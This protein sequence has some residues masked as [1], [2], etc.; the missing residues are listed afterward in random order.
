LWGNKA[1]GAKHLRRALT[2]VRKTF[3]AL[4]NAIL[5]IRDLTPEDDTDLVELRRALT[6]VE[7][8]ALYDDVIRAKGHCHEIG[9]I[10]DAHL[11]GW[12]SG[13]LDPGEADGMRVLFN[14]LRDSDGW[15]IDGMEN[16]LFEAKPLTADI[17]KALDEGDRAA[18]R[19]RA[20]EFNRTL[21]PALQKLSETVTYMLKLEMKFITERA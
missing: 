18:A 15:A 2:E 11:S 7:S 19:K 12:F 20:Q 10:Y 14:T 6:R 21:E 16:L 8:G 1:A 3:D 17:R 13:V 4:R 9:E 5:E